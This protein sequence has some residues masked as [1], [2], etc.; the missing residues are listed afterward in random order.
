MLS[1]NVEV[2]VDL[3]SINLLYVMWQTRWLH[4]IISVNRYNRTS[5]IYYSVSVESKELVTFYLDL[6]M[7]LQA[8]C[9]DFFNF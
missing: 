3:C 4:K 2:G 8:N 1:E 9:N 7:V 6:Q 5:L